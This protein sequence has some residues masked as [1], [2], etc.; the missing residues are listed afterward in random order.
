MKHQLSPESISVIE[1]SALLNDIQ[2]LPC[3]IDGSCC[4]AIDI[5]GI[6][7]YNQ[8]VVQLATANL[9]D[10]NELLASQ[11]FTLPID[12]PLGR[13]AGVVWPAFSGH[14]FAIMATH[15]AMATAMVTLPAPIAD[16]QLRLHVVSTLTSDPES[17]FCDG[18][19]E[20]SYDF[21]D[22]LINY[23]ATIEALQMPENMNVPTGTMVAE[24]T[25]SYLDVTPEQ[26]QR[27]TDETESIMAQ[28]ASEA[29]VSIASMD[30][31][32]VARLVIVTT[33][34]ISDDHPSTNC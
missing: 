8:F 27:L 33:S 22:A 14:Q 31:N 25:L 34:T 12:S 15:R 10:I 29:A 28:W 20:L 7:E 18:E 30:T 3:Y 6:T 17:A 5:D 24:V 2:F 9:A 26:A 23:Q 1:T 4:F 16:G 13:I 19:H 11:C 21:S 32:L